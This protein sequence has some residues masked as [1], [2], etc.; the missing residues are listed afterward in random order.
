MFKGLGTQLN[1]NTAYHPQTNGKT[2]RV[3]HILE[4]IL[5]MYVLDKT[6]KCEDYLHL[7]DFAYN[8]NFQVSPRIRSF[9][10]LYGR[11]CNLQFLGE[12]PLIG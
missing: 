5:R 10:I 8:N 7:V 3:N 2:E 1:F 4:D 9:E 6:S 12:F 11:K